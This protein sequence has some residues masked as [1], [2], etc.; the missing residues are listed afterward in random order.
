MIRQV[1]IALKQKKTHPAT[2][3]SLTEVLSLPQVTK[4]DSPISARG[5]TG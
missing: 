1:L 4:V 3:D 5:P 2:A